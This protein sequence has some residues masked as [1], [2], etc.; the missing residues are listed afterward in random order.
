V[1]DGDIARWFD[2]AQPHECSARE[3]SGNSQADKAGNARLSKRGLQGLFVQNRLRGQCVETWRQERALPSG[4]PGSEAFQ[5]SVK[6]AA[7]ELSRCRPYSLFDITFVLADR[8]AQLVNGQSMS[9]RIRHCHVLNTV[10][11][12]AVAKLQSGSAVR[13]IMCAGT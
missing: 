2:S 12:T 6:R 7:F 4:T 1:K 9:G 11:G 5:W 3:R 13:T 10:P 8:H